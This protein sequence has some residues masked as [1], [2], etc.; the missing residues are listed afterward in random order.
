MASRKVGGICAQGIPS[1][2]YLSIFLVVV[3]QGGV[4]FP[5]QWLKAAYRVSLGRLAVSRISRT[6][7]VCAS[8]GIY[9]SLVGS[10]VFFD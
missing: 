3:R 9:T 8:F 6:P 1:I 2:A 5:Q 4:V 10:S 7:I